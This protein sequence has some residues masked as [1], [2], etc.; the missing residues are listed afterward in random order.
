LRH[1]VAA[2]CELVHIRDGICVLNVNG[3]VKILPQRPP[4][5]RLDH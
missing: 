1:P 2:G 4:D 3:P 5:K